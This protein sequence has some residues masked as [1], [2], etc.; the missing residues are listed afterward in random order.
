MVPP[1]R[2]PSHNQP[3]LATAFFL[4]H[5]LKK[6]GV[7]FAPANLTL[8][9]ISWVEKLT[10]AVRMKQRAFKKC[11]NC[12]KKERFTTSGRTV[13]TSTQFHR[14]VKGILR[15]RLVLSLLHLIW[16]RRY[17]HQACVQ[18][19]RSS[20]PRA[21]LQED[22]LLLTS[23]CQNQTCLPP[24]RSLLQQRRSHT[25]RGRHLSLIRQR[26]QLSPRLL[27][28]GSPTSKPAV[29]LTLVKYDHRDPLR[30]LQTRFPHFQ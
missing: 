14:L 28:R 22:Q 4:I 29:A 11:L 3:H 10:V 9:E 15:P 7:P 27:V 19:H 30:R 12:C 25:K 13:N 5:Q 17:L 24:N 20:K 18:K 8:M 26:P 23:L 1:H 16:I 2:R 6:F 21:H